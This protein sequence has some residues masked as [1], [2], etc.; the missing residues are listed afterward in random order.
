MINQ[1]LIKKEA[2][3]NIKKHY[4]RSVILVFVCSFLLAGGF[5]FT[6]KNLID[7]P[8]AQKEANK[9]INNKKIS[10]TEV[11]DEIE[12]KLPSEKQIKKDIKNK[13]TNGA[14]SYIINETTSSG[15]LVFAIL[16]GINK[17]VFEGKIGSAVLIFI[18]T[19]LLMLFTIIYINTLEV[20]EK[21]YFLEK[22]RYIDTK[23]DRLIYPYKVK[24][25][26]HMAYI[27]FMKSLYQVLWCFTI[28]GGFIKYYEYS[29]IPYILA[30]NPKINKKEAF[31]IS[32]ELTNGNKLKLFYLDLSLIGWS[33]LKLCTFN[34]SG[35]FFS[36]VYK[37]A[38]HAEVYMTLRNKV[39]LDDNYRKLLNDSLL[40]IEER[41]NDTIIKYELEK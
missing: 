40:D 10:G 2:K 21:R 28:I 6:T 30:E 41:I 9:I 31:R 20:G 23:I 24:K 13:Y 38:I 25:T 19:I 26:F 29:L 8:A 4:F 14:I 37:E 3:K 17:V 32:K 1:R 27:L 11:L 39:K 36:D 34:L 15:S 5:N 18:S 16:N 22:R 33:I 12:K 35:I 7:I